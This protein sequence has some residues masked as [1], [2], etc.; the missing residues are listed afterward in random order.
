MFEMIGSGIS[1]QGDICSK[2]AAE[3]MPKKYNVGVYIEVW[4][5]PVR[6]AVSIWDD[7]RQWLPTIC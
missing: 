3:R 6:L 1:E 4:D 5:E 7:T 2:K